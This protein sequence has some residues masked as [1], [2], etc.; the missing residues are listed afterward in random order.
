[1]CSSDL[2]RQ[3]QAAAVSYYENLLAEMDGLYQS[4]RKALAQAIGSQN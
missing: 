3:R 2:A 1:M 4:G